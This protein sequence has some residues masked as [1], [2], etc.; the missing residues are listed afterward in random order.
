M[1]AQLAAL[2]YE[3]FFDIFTSINKSFKRKLLYLGSATVVVSISVW[4]GA[5]IASLTFG[6]TSVTGDGAVSITAGGTDQS[7]TITPSGNGFTVLNGNTGVGTAGPVLAFHIAR[8]ASAGL[9]IENTGSPTA[10]YDI[11][12]ATDGSTPVLNF[13]SNQN[14]QFFFK[15]SSDVNVLGINTAIGNAYN[16]SSL[17]LQNRAGAVGS[18]A[19][20][21]TLFTTGGATTFQPVGFG[22]VQTGTATRTAD[23]VVIVGDDNWADADERMRITH[24]GLVGIGTNNP[25]VLLHVS[26][27]AS[28]TIQIGD[29]S[30]TACL[31]MGD[32]DGSGVTYITANNGVLS[33]TTT[34]PSICP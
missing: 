27:S 2:T 15:N 20:A 28:S 12:A 16:N 11:F 1:T 13:R 31:V 4:A 3:R 33:A 8:S 24:L 26:Q 9:R 25:S 7:V 10:D 14:R 18:K 34:K 22:A 23:F 30:R 6:G 19:F 5:A 32:S 17:E 29:A 21:S